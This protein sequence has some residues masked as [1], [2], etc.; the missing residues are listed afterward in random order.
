LT[1][2]RGSPIL[3]FLLP[4]AHFPGAFSAS[5]CPC[6]SQLRAGPELKALFAKRKSLKEQRARDRRRLDDF[7]AR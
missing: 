6:P 3:H 1:R 2:Y 7:L 4:P 5:D